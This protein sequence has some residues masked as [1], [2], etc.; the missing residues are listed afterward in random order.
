MY[1]NYDLAKDNEDKTTYVTFY[2]PEYV[3]GLEKENKKLKKKLNKAY[4]KLIKSKEY[5]CVKELD[6]N[7]RMSILIALE[8]IL[9]SDKE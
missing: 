8:E 7:S 5:I 3:E 9:G 4:K 6:F 1:C 2:M